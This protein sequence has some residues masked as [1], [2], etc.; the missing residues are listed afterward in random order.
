MSFNF[1]FFVSL[2]N[3][4]SSYFTHSD[5]FFL[6]KSFSTPFFENYKKTFLNDASFDVD[7]YSTT[8]YSY[9]HS[10]YFSSPSIYRLYLLNLLYLLRPLW[11]V[12]LPFF[13][14]FLFFSLPFLPYKSSYEC[15]YYQ[16]K[17]HRYT[18]R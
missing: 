9:L 17:Y 13:L 7:T 6:F 12:G 1:I 18:E 14:F 15:K 16:E 3:L 4:N 8:E 10:I 2:F 11:P 5:T